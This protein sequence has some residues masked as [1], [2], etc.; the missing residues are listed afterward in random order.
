MI[1][2]ATRVVAIIADPIGHVRTPQAFNALMQQ[3]QCDA[4]MVPF[5]VKPDDFPAF[6]VAIPTIQ[7]LVGLVVT[8]PY[9]EIILPYCTDL[10]D[11]ARRVGAVNVVKFGDGASGA[12]RSR[13][14]SNFDGVGFAGGLLA[15]GHVVAGQRVYIAGAGGAAKAVAHALAEQGAAAIGVYNRTEARAVQLVDE[16]RQYYPQLDAHLASPTP[17]NY[18]LAVNSTSLGLKPG[19]ALPFAVNRLPDTAVVAEVVMS[20]DLTPLL[21]SAQHRGLSVHFGRHMMAVQL[22]RIAQFLGLV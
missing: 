13:T 17:D 21:A 9:K 1:S 15:Q 12:Q 7:S 22:D 14:G 20:A 11:A 8:I 6:M 5:N 10:T 2:G 16:L 3:R 19:D 4:V 18:T